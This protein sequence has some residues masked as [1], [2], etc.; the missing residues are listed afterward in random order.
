MASTTAVTISPSIAKL[1]KPVT[2]TATGEKPRLCLSICAPDATPKANSTSIRASTHFLLVV[3]RREIDQHFQAPAR[4]MIQTAAWPVNRPASLGATS[5][6]QS[7]L[8]SLVTKFMRTPA[9]DRPHSETTSAILRE[10]IDR[11]KRILICLD[12]AIT[13]AARKPAVIG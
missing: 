5:A 9:Q 10:E 8:I 1:S 3:G 4:S 2:A 7:Q 12:C 13:N 6:S 11:G